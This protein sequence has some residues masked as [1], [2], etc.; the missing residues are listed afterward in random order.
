MLL[1]VGARARWRVG[2]CRW[3]AGRADVVRGVEGAVGTGRIDLELVTEQPCHEAVAPGI[4]LRQRA[5]AGLQFG[6]PGPAVP[7]RVERPGREQQPLHVAPRTRGEYFALDSRMRRSDRR[8]H[9]GHQHEQQ[10]QGAGEVTAGTAVAAGSGHRR[11]IRRAVRRVP[12]AG[13][14]RLAYLRRP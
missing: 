5:V 3:Q 1:N 13:A 8:V 4:E 11:E 10:G 7:G 14:G 6:Q 12:V 2:G 9:Q